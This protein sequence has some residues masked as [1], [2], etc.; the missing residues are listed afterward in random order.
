MES[1]ADFVFES[2][3]IFSGGGIISM[4]MEKVGRNRETAVWES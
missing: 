2:R 4:R 3:E 1:E